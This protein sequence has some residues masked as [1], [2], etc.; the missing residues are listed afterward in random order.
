M[1]MTP[2]STTAGQMA[3]V[4]EKLLGCPADLEHKIR[5]P[6]ACRCVWLLQLNTNPLVLV[7]QSLHAGVAHLDCRT[8]VI[9]LRSDMHPSGLTLSQWHITSPSRCN[10]ISEGFVSTLPLLCDQNT[11]DTYSAKMP[12]K[13]NW[14]TGGTHLQITWS[15]TWVAKDG[16]YQHI[17]PR[18]NPTGHIPPIR[19]T[20]VA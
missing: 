16:P 7:L 8:N 18:P 9:I 13:T 3:A 19:Q 17:Y 4:V 2:C 6:E 11:T 10:A 1:G 12:M 20:P 15:L 5:L 14:V